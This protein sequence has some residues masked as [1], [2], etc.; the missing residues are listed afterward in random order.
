MHLLLNQI[1]GDDLNKDVRPIEV[2]SRVIRIVTK[3]VNKNVQARHSSVAYGYRQLDILRGTR[4]RPVCCCACFC[5]G[6]WPSISGGGGGATVVLALL[7][8]AQAYA[9]VVRKALQEIASEMEMELGLLV[10]QLLQLYDH[11]ILHV[12]TAYGLSKGYQ[13]VWGLCKGEG[14]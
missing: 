13:Q 6:W 9:D 11:M 4:E 1:K 12:W 7:D 2:M 3:I 10:T 5:T 8:I 14:V